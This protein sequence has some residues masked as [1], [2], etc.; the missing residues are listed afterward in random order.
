MASMWLKK[1]KKTNLFK[2]AAEVAFCTYYP[3][4]YLVCFFPWHDNSGYHHHDHPL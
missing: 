2:K 4:S 3:P 1:E